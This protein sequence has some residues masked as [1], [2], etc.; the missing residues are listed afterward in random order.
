MKILGTFLFSV[1]ATS[2]FLDFMSCWALSPGSVTWPS[3]VIPSFKSWG[4][5]REAFHT[6]HKEDFIMS[7]K[8]LRPRFYSA[9]SYW[10]KIPIC[11]FVNLICLFLKNFLFCIG[12]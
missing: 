8:I 6:L 4:K 2:I 10:G 9:L 1:L 11:F 7:Y 3:C 5:G 12:V